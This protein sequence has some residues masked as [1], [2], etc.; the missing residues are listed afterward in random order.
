MPIVYISSLPF[1]HETKAFLDVYN[2][3]LNCIITASEQNL[4]SAIKSSDNKVSLELYNMM[5]NVKKNK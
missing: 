4:L 5:E 2:N 3:Q 1:F